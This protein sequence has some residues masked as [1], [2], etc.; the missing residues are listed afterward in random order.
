MQ[1]VIAQW[2]RTTWRD[3][4]TNPFDLSAK[5][6]VVKEEEANDKSTLKTDLLLTGFSSL[7]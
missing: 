2:P 7:S 6:G 4:Y 5:T 3:K 1:Y